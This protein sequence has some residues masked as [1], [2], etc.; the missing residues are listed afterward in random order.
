M[1]R[2]FTGST[3]VCSGSVQGVAAL[4]RG[5]AVV[6]IVW[7]GAG[8]GPAAAVDLSEGEVTGYFDT[9]VSV[10]AAVR[11][12]DQ[13][14]SL[15]GLLDDGDPSNDGEMNFDDGNRNYDK[16][17]LVSA[18]TK[19]TH[20]LSLQRGTLGVFA[21][22][23]Y[24]YDYAVA[25]QTT[26]RTPLTDTARRIAGRDFRLLDAYL[27]GDLD[28]GDKPVFVRVG[29]Q[30][31]N[32]GESVFIRNGVGSVNPIDVARLRVA[33]AELRDGLLPVPALSINLGLTGNLS[34]EGFYQL[35]WD[36]TEIEPLGTFFSTNDYG[37]PGAQVAYLADFALNDTSGPTECNGALRVPGLPGV[38]FDTS[39]FQGRT[40]QQVAQ[41]IAQRV[42][43]LAGDP[44]TLGLLAQTGWLL[45][46]V[47]ANVPRGPDRDAGDSGQFGIA[48]RYFAEALNDAEIGVYLARIHSR[49]PVASA[50]T[51]SADAIGI[52]LLDPN[53]DGIPDLVDSNGDGVPDSPLVVLEGQ[54]ALSA[55]YFLEYPE[56]ID[57]V[58][59]SFNSEIG[60]TGFAWQGELSLRQNQPLQID[61]EE[62]LLQGL[63]SLANINGPTLPPIP[64]LQQLG[65]AVENSVR[66]A[67][68]SVF[69]TGQLGVAGF[70][71]AVQ[72]YR[73]KDVFQLQSAVSK[74]L[75]PRLGAD[76]VSFLVEGGITHV[77]DLED[78]AVLR[79][80]GEGYAD[81]TSWGYRV[82]ARA[83]YNNAIGAV[84]LT[85]GLAFYHDVNGTAPRPIGNFVEGRKTV[86]LSLDA[87]YLNV[88]TGRLSY[89]NSFG[90]DRL[91]DRDFVALSASYSF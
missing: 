60:T 35:G 26:A 84:A 61:D 44:A 15:V 65:L 50:R 7:L 27:A 64:Q 71:S 29:N 78:K 19:V 66:N 77:P 4:G 8:I 89:T 3:V 87:E 30:V 74:V 90:A 70:D 21:R 31:I 88:W 56:D 40:A 46:P 11:T 18:N 55:T 54:Y 83:T 36:H 1:I 34:V 47:C 24:F 67:Y 75:G 12:A 53:G 38:A 80:E 58:G 76:Q 33:G 16:G 73:R 43:P 39:E 72:G 9:T 81:P 68:R 32:W 79:Y 23:N 13:D 59:V 91:V 52:R 62:I 5:L 22:A 6:G 69:G 48:F 45:S 49:L 86:S 2:L 42:P 63:S 20:E 85:P 57:I 17:D 10:G 41:L 28:V 37:A 82:V 51:G 14:S 25:D